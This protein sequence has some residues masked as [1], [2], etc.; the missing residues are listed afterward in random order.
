MNVLP[1][2]VHRFLIA[3]AIGLVVAII[4]AL[5]IEQPPSA[6]ITRGDFPAFYTM[7]TLAHRGE[8]AKLYDLETQREVQNAI[9]PSLHGA[10][11]PVAYPAFLARWVEP[12][13]LL[14]AT[15]ARIVWTVAMLLCVVGACAFITRVSSS[16]RGLTWQ[17]TVVALLF[18]PLFLGFLGGQIVGVSVLL[19]SALLYLDRTRGRS[20][21]VALGIVAGLWMYKPHF[22]C[23]VVAVFLLQRR[24]RAI[25]AW[26]GTSAVLWALGASV[27]GTQWLSPWYSFARTFAQIDL[28][29]NAAQMTGI[30]PFLYVVWE[31]I[32][33]GTGAQTGVWEVAALI[34][35][36]MVPCTLA[37]LSRKGGSKDGRDL[38]P[39]VGPL[40]VL[41]APAV[42]FY[43]LAIGALPLLL[44]IHPNRRADLLA[45]GGVL[46]LS[47]IVIFLKDIG[48]AAVCLAFAVLLT[49]LFMRAR[50]RD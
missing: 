35:L 23:A 37:I 18:A 34:S 16:L 11:L 29:T 44:A 43:D 8:G 39:C 47:Q 32:A 9:W 13:A 49:Y 17:T 2:R 26:F 22:S 3:S 33:P 12:L 40:L 25:G 4:G 48:I 45:V 50:A 14:S 28:A 7:A 38:L 36:L 20:S 31:W 46:V 42:N 19:Y 10:V 15:N 41:F 5:S 1:A 27:A 30:V 6:A 21:E 24:W